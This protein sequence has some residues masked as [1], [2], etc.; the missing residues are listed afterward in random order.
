M[1]S[2]SFSERVL[3]I[4]LAP[5][6]ARKQLAG[7]PK[8]L[9]DIPMDTATNAFP[10]VRHKVGMLFTSRSGT[11]FFVD[12]LNRTGQLGE[13]REHMNTYMQNN[14]ARKWRAKSIG[15]Y[16]VKST[17][18]YTTANG[19]YGFKGTAEALLPLIQLG[20]L[21]AHAKTW[22]WITVRRNDII[23]QA[24]SL[25][26]AKATG[27]WHKR[28]RD[29]PGLPP[30][31]PYD[32]A[33]IEKQINLIQRR[34]GQ[35]ERFI[36]HHGLQPLRLVYEEFRDDPTDAL[37]AVFDHVG[38]PAP[39]NLDQLAA[40][41]EFKVLRNSETERYADQFRADLERSMRDFG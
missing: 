14:G 8:K 39:T 28:S 33:A 40:E 34:Q 41:T 1:S 3:Q 22:S 20:E 31:P 11:T 26:R 35:I 13:I 32:F 5:A 38:V 4:G 27:V 25:Y 36:A 21:P 19:V 12:V 6:E 37:H 23:A 30:L 10:G 24:I 17:K 7:S 15:D 18:R 16:V 9:R 29:A 2:L